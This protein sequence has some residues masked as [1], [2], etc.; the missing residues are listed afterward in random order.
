MQC[1]MNNCWSTWEN[2]RD[3][4]L[5]PWS[6]WITLGR[7]NTVKNLIRT[8]EMAEAV[9]LRRGIASGNRVAVHMIVNKYWLPDL[10]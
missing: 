6:V 1:S 2:T 8:F 5:D 3:M 10:L 7:P 9:I 4:K